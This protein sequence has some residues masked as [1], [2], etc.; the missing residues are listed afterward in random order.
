MDVACYENTNR[1]MEMSNFAKVAVRALCSWMTTGTPVNGKSVRAADNASS[2]SRS[3]SGLEAVVR[4]RP[5]TSAAEIHVHN[6][7]FTVSA[8]QVKAA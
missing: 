7:C 3:K 8:G 2:A 6:P 4:T 5:D 1:A